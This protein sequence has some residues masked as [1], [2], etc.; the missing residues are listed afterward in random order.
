MSREKLEELA[1]ALKE[2]H[3]EGL[4]QVELVENDEIFELE[5][6]KKCEVTKEGKLLIHGYAKEGYEWA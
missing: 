5:T 3:K 1:Q 6:L 4:L 2:L